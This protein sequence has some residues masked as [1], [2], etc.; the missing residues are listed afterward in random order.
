MVDE[1]DYASPFGPVGSIVDRPAL[2][3]YMTNLLRGRNQ[4]VCAVAQQLADCSPG[5]RRPRSFA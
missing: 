2:A 1:V 5:T 4:H 3:R